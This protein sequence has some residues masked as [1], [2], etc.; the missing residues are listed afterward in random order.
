MPNRPVTPPRPVVI[1]ATAEL[2]P[3]RMNQP[4]AQLCACGSGL[5]IARCCGLAPG[6]MSPPEAT[7]HLVPL[8]ERAIQ[9]HRQG[10]TETAEQ[11]CLEVLELAPAARAR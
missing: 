6:P 9:A 10:A 7:R 1:A 5:R 11:L 2:P 3:S 8:V 4:A